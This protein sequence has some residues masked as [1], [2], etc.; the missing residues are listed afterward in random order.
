MRHT[1][2]TWIQI[3][4]VQRLIYVG[5]SLLLGV[6][7][8]HFRIHVAAWIGKQYAE[9]TQEQ[10][11]FQFEMAVCVCFEVDKTSLQHTRE[12]G[13]GRTA[14]VL[15]VS[16][17]SCPLIPWMYIIMQMYV[18]CSFNQSDIKHTHTLLPETMGCKQTERWIDINSSGIQLSA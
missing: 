18:L 13:D 17:S 6:E 4:D 12:F 10:T 16:H 7:A 15:L 3:S 2:E 9:S 8:M 5:K 14:G 11:L 1:T